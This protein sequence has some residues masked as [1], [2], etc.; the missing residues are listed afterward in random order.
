MQKRYSE[1]KIYIDQTLQYDTDTSAVLLEHAGDIYY[2]AGDAA[3]ALEYW[4]QA[5]EQAEKDD[6]TKNDR[7]PILILKIKLKKYLKE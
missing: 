6:D 4:R 2:Q 5:L 1:A 3:Q 7:R